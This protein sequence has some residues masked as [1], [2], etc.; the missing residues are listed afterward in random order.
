MTE[1][2]EEMTNK[3]VAPMSPKQRTFLIDLHG[4]A[5]LPVP[6]EVFNCDLNIAE[7]S[8]LVNRLL[9]I[10]RQREAAAKD[11]EIER[12][13]DEKE[14]VEQERLE[15]ALERQKEAGQA[16]RGPASETSKTPGGP[17]P[18]EDID[19]KRVECNVSLDFIVR[20]RD[21]LLNRQVMPVIGALNKL[22]EKKLEA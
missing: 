5:G 3:N 22:I 8:M 16:K 4:R 13:K 19:L 11:A 9:S 14:R 6:D 18:P 10:V 17:V 7:A 12:L 2:E 20:L 21:A 1:R 15:R